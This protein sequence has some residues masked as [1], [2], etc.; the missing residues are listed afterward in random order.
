MACILCAC[1]ND[2]NAL[3]A[4]TPK[5]AGDAAA[6]AELPLLPPCRTKKTSPPA[7]RA[8]R[9]SARTRAPIALEDDACTALLR[10][11]STCS[12]PACLE[13]C[14]V[15]AGSSVWYRDY[16]DC[17][18]G[19]TGNG[20]CSVECAS[21]QNWDCIGNYEY[22]AAT[23]AAYD[24]DFHFIGPVG[25]DDPGR[26]NT[27]PPLEG[28]MVRA[29]GLAAFDECVADNGFVVANAGVGA[30]G[31]TTFTL[32]GLYNGFLRIE[33]GAAREST[34]FYELPITGA[35][36]RDSI[37]FARTFR[38]YF[39]LASPGSTPG[40]HSMGLIARMS[41]PSRSIAWGCR[42]GGAL[43]ARRGS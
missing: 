20:Q 2:P 18:F 43:R 8:P 9:T 28:A 41:G 26:L 31:A 36:R 3:Y 12:N 4:T 23:N 14:Y 24:V 17:V 7:N 16:F 33:G 39:V 29:C 5:D 34:A 30:Y 25:P 21:G 32:R 22:R 15:D 13:G 19:T 1:S 38:N 42:A 40:F 37:F 35:Q 10:C 6:V 27:F 11:K